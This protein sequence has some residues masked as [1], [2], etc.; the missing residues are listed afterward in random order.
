MER[1]VQMIINSDQGSQ[2]TYE[3]WIEYLKGEGIRISMPAGQAGMVKE[4][5]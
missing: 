2:F 1:Q 4:E 3:T 5:P